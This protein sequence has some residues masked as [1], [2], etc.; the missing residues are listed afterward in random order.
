MTVAA[1]F[2]TL[3][4]EVA[5]GTGVDTAASS[6]TDVTGYLRSGE[7]TLCGRERELD[8]FT[9][10]TARFVL[11]NTDRR[12]DPLYS[13][14]PYFGNLLPLTQ[15]RLRATWNAVTYDV[16]RGYIDGWPQ[17]YPNTGTDSVVEITCSDGFVVLG[18]A[19]LPDS[20]WAVTVRS[21]SPDVWYRLGE[22]SGTIMGDSWVGG[23][24][25]GTYEGGATF[26][27]RESL[28]PY[29]DG[30][31]GAI[32]FNGVD[33]VGRGVSG[34]TTA[35]DFTFS[36]VAKM[37][38]EIDVSGGLG[39][40]RTLLRQDKGNVAFTHGL[41]ILYL[42]PAD[43]VSG[44]VA[45]SLVFQSQAVS[46]SFANPS[47]S[48][49]AMSSGRVYFITVTYD[50]AGPTAILYVN[51][52]AQ[53]IDDQGA[54][55]LVSGIKGHLRIGGEATSTGADFASWNG[56]LGEYA[57]WSS[58]FT[59][60]DV[61]DLYAAFAAPWDGDDSGAR[62]GRILDAAAW[63]ASLRD[64]DTGTSILGPATLGGNALDQCQLVEST[65]AGLLYID[66]A[67]KVVFVSR[68]NLHSESRFIT[69][70]AT[71]GDGAGEIGYVDI[72]LG[73][74]DLVSIINSARVSRVGGT[75]Q[76]YSDATS[77]STYGEIWAPDLTNLLM[78]T[79]GEALDRATATVLRYKDPSLRVE[80][81]T[82]IPWQ[83]DP[84]NAWPQVLG[85]K[86]G[87]RITVKRRPQGVGSAISQDCQ[88]ERITHRF[89]AGEWATTWSLSSVDPN[90]TLWWQIGSGSPRNQIGTAK[91]GY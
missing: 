63:P 85:R 28:L 7:V 58:T 32:E 91:V 77:A 52:V 39:T 73:G 48:D 12:F 83:P 2:P 54:G 41:W 75:L 70:N 74:Y 15:I 61:A 42:T 6:W 69:S 16:W 44:G 67:G 1:N 71:F 9:A 13:S 33:M 11:S 64:L 43:G 81:I 31:G 24:N 35:D 27:H 8:R 50:G 3:A 4:L 29:G 14:G 72:V 59:A 36:I 25:T 47:W 80:S 82:I 68:T 37:P 20:V 66:G 19:K 56:T 5:F 30:T 90:E 40:Y 84:T 46:N 78:A 26:N 62:I 65:E 51:G 45:G 53:T 76:Q 55:S 17:S 79:D 49:A 22:Q 23:S 89:A 10:G 57:Q 87:D 18:R 86:I 38:D 34:V 21:L 60:N 88:I